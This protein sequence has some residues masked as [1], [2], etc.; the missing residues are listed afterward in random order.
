MPLALTDEQLSAVYAAAQPLDV[1]DRAAFL[2]TVA[3][4]LR[5]RTDPGDGDVHRAV[6]E[7]QRL[8]FRRRSTRRT[9]PCR[10]ARSVSPDA[11]AFLHFYNLAIHRLVDDD[12]FKRRRRH[13]CLIQ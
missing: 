10:C 11:L 6:R 4:A 5:N 2:Q 8:Y 7:A 12:F 13:G 1:A 9:R 3:A